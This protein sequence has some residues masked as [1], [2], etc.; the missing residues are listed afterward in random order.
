MNI[1]VTGG[2][3]F[4]G[5]HITDAYIK[6]G[7][8]VSVVDDLTTGF[9]KNVNK[10]ARFYQIDIRDNEAL[11]TVIKR[12][13][14]DIIN[15]HAARAAVTES[16]KNPIPTLEVNV[17]GTANLALLAGEYGIKKFIFASTGGAMYGMGPFKKPVSEKTPENPISP[18]GLSKQLA[19]QTIAYYAGTA[20]FEYLIFRYAN[21]FG[22]RQNPKGEAG[23]IAIF[24]ALMKHGETPTIFGDGKKTRDYVYINDIVAANV[25]GL[26]R[27]VN[28]TLNLGWEKE[29]QD[30]EVFRTLAM[31]T[32]FTEQPLYA[33]HR[34]GE[35]FR[36]SLN[37]AKA[38]ETIGWKP[39][40][41]FQKGVAK[42]VRTL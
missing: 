30:N 16:I 4:I 36:C 34:N 40:T 42:T 39:K 10:K 20:C 33:P 25:I 7:H 1:L 3:G 9:R 13:K 31:Y 12:E 27:G 14:P 26:K 35:V 5:S 41:P 22:P 19:E 23:V 24:G 32:K 6:K 8:R 11:R 21:V 2:A 29:T 15:H 38:A 37:A 17:L 18:Y 28:T